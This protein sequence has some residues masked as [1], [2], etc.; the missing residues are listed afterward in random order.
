MKDNNNEVN[1]YGEQ[2]GYNNPAPNGM[3]YGQPGQAPNGM[4]YG[5]PSPAPNGMNYGQPSP[6]PNGMN[7]GQPG[8]APNGMNYGQPNPAPNGM[9]YGQPN[10]APNG[11]NYGQPN[12]APNGMNYGQPNPAPNGMNY[13]QPNPAPNGMN[14]GQPS[15][16]P[17]GM[18]YGQ[19]NPAPNGMNYGQPNPAPNGMNYGQPLQQTPGYGTP[20]RSVESKPVYEKGLSG[21][22]LFLVIG[23][24][25]ASII[26]LIVVLI[27]TLSGGRLS[28]SDGGYSSV[29]KVVEE[30]LKGINKLDKDKML[31][32]YPENIS[33]ETK[34]E[35]DNYIASYGGDAE[36]KP[37]TLKTDE[38]EVKYNEVSGSELKKVNDKYKLKAKKVYDVDIT[39][40]YKQEIVI[41][42]EGYNEA[43]AQVAELGGKYYLLNFKVTGGEIT[44]QTDTNEGSTEE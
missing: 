12:P 13:G 28:K 7:Y 2:S 34:K 15:Q 37:L 4:N 42:T 31:S 21:G 25:A 6:A 17:N 19:P 22:K 33:K 10:P 38:L 8:P 23:I 44:S 36:G 30:Y 9:N 5:Q 11:M 14:Y 29:D 16:A 24:I 43:K 40:P 32:C 41:T 20:Y 35:I 27:L 26:A 39:I 1:M 18:N 3:N